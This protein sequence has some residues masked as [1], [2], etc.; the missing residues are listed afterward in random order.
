MSAGTT[1]HSVALTSNKIKN[2]KFLKVETKST[3]LTENESEI[4]SM[5]MF[6]HNLQLSYYKYAHMIDTNTNIE[7]SFEIPSIENKSSTADTV[8]PCPICQGNGE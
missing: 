8:G 7:T 6:T 3:L 4:L 2:R 5:E 1:R